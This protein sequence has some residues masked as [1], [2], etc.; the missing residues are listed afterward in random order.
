VG[1]AVAS[2][3]PLYGQGMTSALLQAEVLGAAVDRFGNRPRLA[4]TIA[5]AT[6]RVVANPWTTATGAD[7]IYAATE[8]RRPRGATV[9]NRYVERVTRAAAVDET[10][11]AG[12][13]GVQQLLAAP[14]TLFRPSIVLRSWRYG[15][16]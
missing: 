6:A 16:G 9:I 3:N 8:G 7:F 10:V 11:N 1:D 13:T 5:R 14:P 4:P 2:F 12:F 15:A